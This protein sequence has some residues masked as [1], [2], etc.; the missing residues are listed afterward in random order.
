MLLSIIRKNDKLAAKRNPS[1]ERNRF[2]KFIIYFMVAFW[3]AYLI[4]IGITL[5]LGLKEGVQNMEAYHVFNQFIIYL[6][7]ADFLLRF[8]GQPATSQEIKPYLLF[9]IK[10]NKLIDTFLLQSG[11]SI[12]NLFWF[13]LVLPFA[14]ITIPETYGFWGVILYL[15]GMWLLFIMNNYWYQICKTL[16]RQ[17]TIYLLL[18]AAVYGSILAVDLLPKTN[19]FGRFTMNLGE[20]FIQGNIIAFIGVIAVILLL[21]IINRYMQIYLMYKELGKVEDS[22]IKRVS[23]FKFLDRYGEVGEFMRLELKLCLRNKAVKHQ[24]RMG[25]I[26]MLTFSFVLAFTDVYNGTGMSRF[27]CIYNYAILSVMT[28]GQI[29][30]FEGNY[31]DGLL[32]RRTSIFNLLLAKFYVNC[33]I[34][35][36]PFAFM[37]IPV[38]KGKIDLLMAFAYMLFTAGVV[39]ALLMQYAVYNKK[40]I[41]LNA[42]IMR[43]NRGSSFFQTIV[44]C[45]ALFLPIIFNSLLSSLFSDETTYII[46][47][48]IGAIFI[49]THRIWIKNI[50]TRMMARKFE[51][52]EGFR[53]T[54]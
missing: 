49:M 23:Q 31:I 29:M 48:I 54:R 46:M 10:K 18:P 22:N 15:F 14:V 39:F 2:A 35:L 42:T 38:F 1:F 7:F 26:I 30:S 32:C 44:I 5:A 4:F 36:I 20:G 12:F 21:F 28:L 24:V 3:A 45:C 40:T 16:L 33:F 8:M 41:A 11:L 6:L 51:N 17:K 34:L 19:Y 13:F 43:S 47:L 9:P 27:I 37:M 52:L 50:Y 53:E 25:F